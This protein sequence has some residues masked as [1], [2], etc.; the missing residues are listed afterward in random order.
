MVIHFLGLKAFVTKS[1][2]AWQANPDNVELPADS[3]IQDRLNPEEMHQGL[4][5]F[6]LH[7][8]R[9]LTL[10]TSNHND[11]RAARN[12]FLAACDQANRNHEGTLGTTKR[13]RSSPSTPSSLAN[14]WLTIAVYVPHL[15]VVVK[16]LLATCSSEA[17]V[18]RM[19]SKEGFI[20][21]KTRNQLQHAFT[22]ALVRCCINSQSIA[23]NFTDL[24]RE[25]LSEDDADDDE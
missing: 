5:A 18:E 25:L 4:D 13:G 2:P 20:H 10:F 21:D 1:W 9:E 17:A 23:G 16:L 11:V 7:A 15:Y 8:I 3:R 14:F 24:L 19:F 6:L 22:E 12:T